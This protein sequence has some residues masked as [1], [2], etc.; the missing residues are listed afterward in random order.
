MKYCTFVV[1]YLN[2]PWNVVVNFCIMTMLFVIFNYFVTFFID[3]SNSEYFNARCVIKA[4]LHWDKINICSILNL[5]I[6][7]FVCLRIH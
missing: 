1:F 5:L 2:K 4:L 3:R 7:T 6:D